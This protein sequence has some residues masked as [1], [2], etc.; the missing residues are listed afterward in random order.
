MPS[1]REISAPTAMASSCA[2][3]C[4]TSM[5][6]AYTTYPSRVHLSMSS[7]LEMSAPTAMASPPDSLMAATTSCAG[8]SLAEKFTTTCGL[9]NC[10]FVVPNTLTSRSWVCHGSDV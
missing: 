1:S 8:P 10:Y 5:S 2:C 3:K 9:S 4:H 7:F 6:P